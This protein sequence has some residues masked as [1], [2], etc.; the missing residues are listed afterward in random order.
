M[1]KTTLLAALLSLA[2]AGAQ[3][4][5]F[6]EFLSKPELP[7]TFMGLDCSSTRYYGD[8]MTVGANEMKGLFTKMDELLVKE[9]SKYDLQKALHRTGPVEYAINIAESA[10]AKIDT[11]A[12]IVPADTAPRAPFTPETIAGLVQRYDY[13][14]GTSGVGLVFIIETINKRSESEI[15]WA[16]FVNLATKQLLFTQKISGTGAGFGFRNH[17]AAPLN[18]GI[19]QIKYNYGDWKKKFA[20]K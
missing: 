20:G 10:N 8:P 6:G 17:W 13:P 18:A 14:A 5:T 19:K 1:F 11:A 9:A 12:I 4:Q 7:L 3:A 16:A 2:A 15:F